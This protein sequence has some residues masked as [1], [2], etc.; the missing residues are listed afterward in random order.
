MSVPP[1]LEDQFN[2]AYNTDRLPMCASIPDY[3]RARRFQAVMGEPKYITVHEMASKAVADSAEWAAW[4]TAETPGWTDQIRPNMV[5][6]P[7][8]PGVY[9]KVFPQ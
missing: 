5:H 3:I 1:E 4:S 2:Q 7:G 9:K 8:S 6:A